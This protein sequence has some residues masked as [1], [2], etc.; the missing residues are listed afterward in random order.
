MASSQET[1]LIVDD[2][3]MIRWILNKKLSKEGYHCE[4]S[5][6]AEQALEK[7]RDT[8]A[9]LAILD[10]NMPGRKGTRL[11][12]QIRTSFPETAVIMASAVTEST[13]IAQCI[14][15][16][17][18][19]YI[20][21][22]FS[23]DE[24]SLSVNRALEKRRLEIRIQQYRQHLRQKTVEH[25]A[26]IRKSFL[27]TIETLVF[28]LES[29]DQYTAGHSRRTT[30]IAL[31]VGKEIG[32]FP[33][34]LEDL[35][36]AALLHDVGKIAIDPDILNKPGELTPEEYRHIMTHAIIGPNIVKPM[37]NKGVVEIISHHHDHYDGSGLDQ[38]VS[39]EDIP[40]GARILAV[41]DAFDAM[42]SDRPYRAAMT[43]EEA[44]EEIGRCR[45]TQFDPVVA[46]TFLNTIPANETMAAAGTPSP[47]GTSPVTSESN[48]F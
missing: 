29:N 15:D 9:E 32:L 7:L 25:A 31:S 42:T 33:D 37:V 44:I 26:E 5:G 10:I 19:D 27:N 18:Q 39:G 28:A 21:K 47:K 30:E 36:W 46:S 45:S 43:D 6:N 24:V 14:K 22:P 1:I 40:L 11:L 2:E 48:P 4:E 17:A 20:R 12:P 23:L 13:V 3:E 35:R 38:I 16:G 8:P 41:A 34:E